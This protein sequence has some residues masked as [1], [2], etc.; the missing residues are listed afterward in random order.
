MKII[1][2]DCFSGISG[3]MLLGAFIDAGLNQE[4]LTE[5]PEKLNLPQVKVT[6]NKV[7]KNG[8]SATKVDVTFPEEQVHRHLADIEKIID[9]ADLPDPVKIIS[10]KIFLNLA[11]AEARVH[12]TD[13]DQ[14]HFHEVGALDAIADITGVALGFHELQI[15]QAFCSKISVG[16]GLVKIAHGT[17]PVPAPATA[18]LLEGFMLN[19]GPV[20]KE[21]VTPTGAA[22]LA[23]LC[24]QTEIPSFHLKATGYGAG[25]AEFKDTPNVLRVQLGEIQKST[26]LESDEI[27]Q[28][29]CNIDDLNPQI[30]P[31]LIEQVLQAGAVEAFVTPVVM[32][33]GRPGHLFSI[34]CA[35]ENEQDILNIIFKETTSI[36][37]RKQKLTR[38]ILKR[39]VTDL[40][41]SFG[42]IKVKEITLPD[43]SIKRTPEFEDCKKVALETGEALMDIQ[44][45][46]IEEI[47]KT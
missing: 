30:Y 2:F 44:K 15:D 1:Y 7:L 13:V 18:Y 17:Y 16:G 3:D 27:L 43:G 25:T 20:D 46:L 39:R 24:E 29:E 33:K 36:G 12:G 38:S 10:K 47:N 42:I 23:T 22:V 9:A 31:Y 6:I 5:L 32:K 8:L 34:L 28:I 45:K 19:Q 14:I 21:L 41:T 4:L 35:D 37:V 40:K 26:N 11:K